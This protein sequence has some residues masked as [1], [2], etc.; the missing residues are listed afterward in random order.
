MFSFAISVLCCAQLLSRPGLKRSKNGQIRL[1]LPHRPWDAVEQSVA[2]GVLYVY[3][4]SF[5]VKNLTEISRQDSVKIMEI[6]VRRN[7][8]PQI[9]HIVCIK[10]QSHC[11]PLS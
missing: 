4:K 8:V 11:P 2:Y 9:K 1:A 6:R 7:A 5:N 3:D 10:R